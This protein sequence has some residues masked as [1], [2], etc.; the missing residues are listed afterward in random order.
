MYHTYSMLLDD[1]ANTYWFVDSFHMI[2]DGK[3]SYRINVRNYRDAGYAGEKD[4]NRDVYDLLVHSLEY[5][6][7]NVL[8]VLS[9]EFPDAGIEVADVGN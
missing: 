1:V 6:I 3:S 4:V 2:V 9:K 7:E 5:D 8:I